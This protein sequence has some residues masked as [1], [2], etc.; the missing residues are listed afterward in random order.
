MNKKTIVKKPNNVNDKSARKSAGV[1]ATSTIRTQNSK[2]S[3]VLQTV[4]ET[5]KD[6]HAAGLID[7]ATMRRFDVLS[8]PQVRNYTPSQIK[9][10]RKRCNV[11]QAVFA[12]HLNVTTSSLQKWEIGDKKPNGTALKLLDLVDRKGLEV[13]L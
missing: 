9:A 8:L 2:I 12:K 5:A 1:S 10:L 6:L 7:K 3:P 13:L 11:S 4:L